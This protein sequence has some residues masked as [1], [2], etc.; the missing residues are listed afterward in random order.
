MKILCILLPHFPL[1]CELLRHPGLQESTVVTYAVGSQKLVLDYSPELD[2][3]HRDMPLQQALSL[4]GDIEIIPADMP[5][6]RSIFN[7]ILDALETKS[8]LVEGTELGEIYIGLDGLHL[9]YPSNDL[10]ISAVREAIH[11][12]FDARLGMAGGKFLAYLTALHSPPGGYKTLAGNIAS[13]LRDLPCDV[14]PVSVKSKSKL[15]EF[16][17]HTLGQIASLRPGPL[18]AQFGP[19]GKRIWQLA[20]GQDDTPLLPRSAEETIEESITLPSATVSLAAMLVALEAMLSR[21]FVKLAPRGMGIARINVWTRT[22]VSEYWERKIPFKEPAMNT[23]TAISRIKQ[24]IENSPQPGPIEQLGMKI[25]GVGRQQG[26]Q[27]SFLPEVR[28]QDHLLNDVRQLE[29][30]LGGPQLF[31][32]KEV[33]P[34]SRIPERR[35]ALTPLDR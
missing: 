23:K 11:D 3:L 10:L 6:Y 25:T 5:H 24:I 13:F 31:I 32:V 8:P 20:N 27:K 2:S 19:E 21:A 12:A 15:H 17:L 29:Y 1:K 9:I 30:R 28:A 18:Q 26:R 7:E 35:R 34:W 22:W 14:L 16:G 4:H 33:E